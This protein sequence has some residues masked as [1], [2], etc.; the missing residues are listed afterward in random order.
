MSTPRLG[1]GQHWRYRSSDLC[2]E[3]PQDS[4]WAASRTEDRSRRASLCSHPRKQAPCSPGA[5]SRL[6][7]G[8][9]RSRH[10]AGSVTRLSSTQ[11]CR[12]ARR[13][14]SSACCTLPAPRLTGNP[15]CCPALPARPAAPSRWQRAAVSH[16]LAPQHN[17]VEQHSLK[18]KQ[19]VSAQI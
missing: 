3:H 11:E 6:C 14:A 1:C 15:E 7:S 2:P 19:T 5:A 10:A 4:G 12:A 13:P 17:Q 9:R 16:G 8:R 18:P